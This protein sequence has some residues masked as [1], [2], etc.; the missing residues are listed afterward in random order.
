MF[1]AL[2]VSTHSDD[3][4]EKSLLHSPSIG[5][6]V[7][8]ANTLAAG[9]TYRIE[10]FGYV[11]TDNT[12]TDSTLRVKLGSNVIVAALGTLPTSLVNAY[13]DVLFE[14]TVFSTGVAGA[15]IGQG[16]SLIGAAS[17]V[18]NVTSRRLQM[19]TSASIDTT[20]DLTIDLTYQWAAA[21][22]NNAITHTNAVIRRVN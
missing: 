18:G 7:I 10:I 13:Y 15:V 22:P 21:S 20:V 17:G 14:F 1:V 9:D 2:N 3:T 11:S 16:R 4:T 8:P 12:N 19:L 5:T 6:K